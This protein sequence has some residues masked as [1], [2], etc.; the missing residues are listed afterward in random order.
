MLVYASHTLEVVA[1]ISNDYHVEFQNVAASTTYN[2]CQVEKLLLL[3]YYL[4]KTD[5][6]QLHILRT[7]QHS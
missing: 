6:N 1:V 7:Y 4:H 3:N 2:M 5:R